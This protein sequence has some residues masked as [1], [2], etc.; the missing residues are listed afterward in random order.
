MEILGLNRIVKDTLKTCLR[1][2][3]Q[4][5]CFQSRLEK[6]ESSEIVYSIL[7]AIILYL[8]TAIANESKNQDMKFNRVQKKQ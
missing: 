5:K 4:W 8:L 7:R 6:Q 3:N 1:K 2:L